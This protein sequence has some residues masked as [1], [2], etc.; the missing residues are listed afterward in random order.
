MH[1]YLALGDSYTC[2]EAVAK[3]VSFPYLLADELNEKGVRIAT[4]KVIATTGWTTD[5]LQGAI[6]DESI[7][8]TYDLVTLLIGANN[9]YRGTKKGYT[10]KTY[11]Q[12]FTQL[13]SQAI[14]FAGDNR[15]RV[16]V[17]SIP[18]WGATPFADGQNKQQIAQEIDEYNAA[19]KQ[20]AAR[21]DVTYVDITQISRQA[22]HDPQLT[23]KDGLHPTGKMY[24]Q[25]VQEL[26]PFVRL[27]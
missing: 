1:S 21:Q 2:G 14:R 15:E 25:W 26:L 6:N 24:A 9:Q 3:E 11:Q 5:E 19:N 10:L 4:P 13:L 23:A 27:K 20:E 18:D 7:T 8:Q 12:E 17:L 22:S 16:A